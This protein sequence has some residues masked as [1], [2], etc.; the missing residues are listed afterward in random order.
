MSKLQ[1]LIITVSLIF[2]SLPGFQQQA[3]AETIKIGLMAGFNSILS[4]EAYQISNGVNLAAKAIDRDN[5]KSYKFSIVEKDTKLNP[6]LAAQVFNELTKGPDNINFIIG[7]QSTGEVTQTAALAEKEEVVLITPS[8]RSDNNS[9]LSTFVFRTRHSQQQESRF[10]APYILRETKNKPLHTLILDSFAGY[11]FVQSFKPEYAKIG[12]KFGIFEDLLIDRP[13][14]AQIIHKL[15][16]NKASY[17]L[18]VS[19]GVQVADLMQEA[20]YAGLNL[21]FFGTSDNNNNIILQ[22][23]G[24]LAEGFSFPY[25]FD[26][27]NNTESASFASEYNSAFRV[28]AT[29]AAAN[30]YDALMLLSTCM[31]RVGSSA[32]A[33]KSCLFYIRDYPGAGGPL[34]LDRNG[35]CRRQLFIKTVKNGQFIR[36]G[37]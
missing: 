29:Q 24:K 12:G 21:K 10:F 35:N 26:P 15:E 28:P 5:S 17:V 2:F 34:T 14:Y 23:A 31:E 36:L 37:S 11:A 18:V 32:N 27:E 19:L 30:A 9:A 7:P 6:N 25:A 8:A 22:R 20:D 33:V 4:D 13:N 3:E 1:F 16:V